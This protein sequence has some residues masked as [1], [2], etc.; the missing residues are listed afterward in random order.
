MHLLELRE[1][2]PSIKTTLG[3]GSGLWPGQGRRRGPEAL[4][5]W[6]HAARCFPSGRCPRLPRVAGCTA[7]GSRR[8]RLL[9]PPSPLPSQRHHKSNSLERKASKIPNLH[10]LLTLTVNPPLSVLHSNCYQDLLG[11]L[12]LQPTAATA[13]GGTRPSPR[14]LAGRH[15]G[16]H[17]A[18]PAGAAEGPWRGTGCLL[19]QGDRLLL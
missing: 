5:F 4:T 8:G 19:L 15:L 16:T 13:L 9:A 18:L 6:S 11:E 1:K 7:P 3:F 2:Q 10:L 14:R 12:P 17:Q